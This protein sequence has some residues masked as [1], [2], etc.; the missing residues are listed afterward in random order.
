MCRFLL[1]KSNRKRNPAHILE[2]FSHMAKNSTSYDGDVQGDGWGFS[3]LEDNH[4]ERYVSTKPI[5]NDKNMFLTFPTSRIFSIHARSAS[6]IKHKNNIAY[7]QPYIHDLYSYVFNGLL[8]GVTL[9]IPGEIGAQK[10]WNLLNNHLQN[11][12]LTQSV[13]KTIEKL[14]NNA[15][16][17][18]ALNIGLAGEKTISAYCYYTKYPSY[19][20]LHYSD[21]IENKIITSEVI[22]GFNFNVMS[23]NSLVTL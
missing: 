2:L 1:Y 10:I 11:T 18:Q 20:S 12:P 22:D 15:Q 17:I 19:Y 3:W 5:W 8:K 16:N 13:Y 7:N 4:W 9:S 6:F 21:T 14:K 23:S